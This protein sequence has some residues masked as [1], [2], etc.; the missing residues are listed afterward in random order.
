MKYFNN[1]RP[2]IDGTAIPKIT[3]HQSQ[4]LE[5]IFIICFQLVV[6]DKYLST[7]PTS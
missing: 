1:K 6:F 4:K 2:K 5:P 7:Q 3:F